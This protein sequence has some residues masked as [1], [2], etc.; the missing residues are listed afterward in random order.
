MQAL[1][2]WYVRS[3]TTLVWMFLGQ[4]KGD[5]GARVQR[6]DGTD[7]MLDVA[8]LVRGTL[9]RAVSPDRPGASAAVA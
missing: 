3:W 6:G 9:Q 1:L 2:S 7:G 4:G 8:R 5:D